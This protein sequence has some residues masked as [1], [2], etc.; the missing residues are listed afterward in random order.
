MT[1]GFITSRAEALVFRHRLVWLIAFGLLT[2]VMAAF[3]SRTHVDAGFSKQLPLSH[4]YIQTFLKHQE[5]FGGAN[6][7]L[8]ALSVRDGDIFTP[9]FFQTLRQTTDE[10]FFLPGVDRAQVTS[11]FT[12]NVRFVEVVEDGFSGG[13]VIPAN[14]E[15]TPEG[16]ERVRENILKS[17]RIGQLVAEDFSAALIS[18]QLLEIDPTTGRRLDYFAVAEQ[19]ERIRERQ[20]AYS[21]ELDLDIHIIGFAKAVGE[22]SEG[23]RAVILF[24][25]ISFLVTSFAVWRYAQSF[26]LALWPVL[27]STVAV[28]WQMGLLNA[29][30]YGI[31]PMS[32]LVPFLVFAI[33]VSHGVQMVRAFRAASLVGAPP[34]E[35]ARGAFRAL[36]VPGGVALVTD[37]I[38]FITILLIDIEMIRE[39]AITAS[40]GVA[41]I[42][43]T[44]LFL[45]P[46]LLSYVKVPASFGQSMVARRALNERLWGSVALVTTPAGSLVVIATA[47]ALFAWGLRDARRVA[48]GDLHP[49]VPEL[50]ES[51]RYNRDTAVITDKFNIGVDVIAVIAETVPDAS[52][53]YE[54]MSLLDSFEWS[55]RSVPGIQSTASLPA[56]AKLVNAGWNEGNPK[57]RSLP[58]D[59]NLLAQAISPVETSSGLLNED[60]SVLPVYL[61]LADHKAETIDRVIA[62]V[63]RFRESHPSEKVTLRL[64]TGNVGVMAATNEVVRAAQFPM[65]AWV[66][67]AIMLLCLLTFRSL[68]ATFCIVAPLALSSAL[69]YALMFRLEIGLKTSTLPVVALG[70]GI[71]VDYGIYLFSRLNELLKA[72]EPFAL[73]IRQSLAQTG[74]AILFTGVTLALGV[75]TWIFSPLKF[76]ADMGI[77][78]TFMFLVNMLGALLLLP[79][80]A[81]WLY[82]RRN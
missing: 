71:G 10:V 32:I 11:L 60:S 44:N 67:A 68:R 56:I 50:R 33:G 78:L 34:F 46:I 77:L 80:L 24:F 29:L 20:A 28:V 7:V 45:L 70:V 5:A 39:L 23:A 2:L 42:L 3:A 21:D 4:P 17:G 12:P 76:Q 47:A 51:S 74:S 38:G 66:F 49:G 72:G 13:N 16:L 73:A 27:C 41:V 36:F 31:D 43:V 25:G 63:E 40:L 18:A 6:R 15:P 30:G 61:F 14:F 22:I 64:A 62:A 65:L 69:A 57:W 48:I 8:I 52:I 79:A 55:M 59:P 19:L 9:E 26:R 53:D 37:T 54:V 75:G 1:S 35:A 58:R 81:R 82:G